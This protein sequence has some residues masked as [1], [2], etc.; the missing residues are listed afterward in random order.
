[1]RREGVRNMAGGKER[2]QGVLNIGVGLTEIVG[3][4]AIDAHIFSDS[5]SAILKPFV[6][7]ATLHG[8]QAF[9]D[10]GAALDHVRDTLLTTPG[11]AAA[12]VGT[13]LLFSEGVIRTVRGARSF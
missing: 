12:G 13:V 4:G 11:G 9:S 1:M 5:G 2:F 7:L 3:A 6:E 10:A 8:S